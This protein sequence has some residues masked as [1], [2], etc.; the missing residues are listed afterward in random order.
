MFLIANLSKI[1]HGGWI[2]LV[3]GTLLSL[4]M[5][6]WYKGKQIHKKFIPHIPLEEEVPV[7]QE[8]SR[9]KAIPKYATHLIYLSGSDNENMVE[10]KSMTS[11]L[12]APVKK[13][14]IYW[15]VHIEVADE[16]YTM[17]YK[18]KTL[19]R[20]DVYHITFN[21]GF[22]IEPRIDLFLRTIIEELKT[23]GELALE[24]T[25]D[26]KYSL[27]PIGDYKFIL[28]DSY[29]SSD[30]DLPQWKNF[31]LKA[32]YNLKKIA[33]REEENFGLEPSNVLVEKYPLI[34]SPVTGIWL[35]RKMD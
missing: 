22:R 14:D 7:L 17:E 29:L 21:L 3:I 4:I 9:D 12:K 24:K 27:N 2:T 19:A 28:G 13:A 23:S 33:V 25:P 34:V 5:Y 32:Y 15:F 30:N 20:H 35:K 1:H 8:L 18:L 26:L 31:L 6:I 11:I 16:P 10:Q